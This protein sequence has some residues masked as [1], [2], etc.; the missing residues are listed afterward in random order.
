MRGLRPARRAWPERTRDGQPQAAR[1]RYRP[2]GNGAATARSG[3]ASVRNA[4]RSSSIL[5]NAKAVLFRAGPT[6]GP[7][8]RCPVPYAVASG[9]CRYAL[10]S[11]TCRYALAS[12]R[13]RPA[14][15]GVGALPGRRADSLTVARTYVL[16][17]PTSH[18]TRMCVLITSMSQ[19]SYGRRPFHDGSRQVRQDAPGRRR[20]T[21][22]GTGPRGATCSAGFGSPLQRAASAGR[23]RQSGG[24]R[25]RARGARVATA[26]LSPPRA[27]LPPGGHGAAGCRACR[28]RRAAAGSGTT[29]RR[30][31]ARA[32]C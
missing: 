6:R 8:P 26:G 28:T 27:L 17:K 31:S 13:C 15:R 21:V 7:H 3:S 23:P 29:T 9:T 5:R 24:L 30:A 1:S 20:C 32:P 18:P 25:Q 22:A 16:I 11:G 10:A 4:A 2:L 14:G 12:G 19:A